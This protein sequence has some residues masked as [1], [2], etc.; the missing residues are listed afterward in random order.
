MALNAFILES[1]VEM[2]LMWHD[3]L[4]DAEELAY[5][6]FVFPEISTYADPLTV[7]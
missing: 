5:Y 1:L 6:C 3:F 2:V 7:K 4:V